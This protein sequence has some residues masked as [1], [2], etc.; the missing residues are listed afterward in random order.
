MKNP[1]VHKIIKRVICVFLLSVFIFTALSMTASVVI[2]GVM[3]QRADTLAGYAEITYARS[4]SNSARTRVY[5]DSGENRLSG[6]L[7]EAQ[8]PKGLIIIAPGMNSNSDSHLAEIIFF[9][10]KGYAVLAYDSTGVCESEGNSRV[11]LQQSKRDL[12]AAIFY[13][14]NDSELKSLPIY[15][16]GHSLGGYAVAAV[17]CEADVEAAICLSGFDSPVQT[18][19]GKAKE[20]IGV[21]ADIEYPFLYLQNRFTFGD[22]ADATA[23]ESINSVDTPILIC[24]GD[25]D[26]TIPY[27]LSVYSHEDEITNGNASFM[28]VDE[29]YRDGHV[30]MW[31]SEESA[32]YMSEVQD[33]YRDLS[34][35]Y[36]GDIPQRVLD[37]F[38]SGI[39]VK[40]AM[41]LDKDFMNKILDFMQSASK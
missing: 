7:Y 5:F 23:V 37:D 22:D 38:Y 6:Y 11:G 39:D 26:D 28:E 35:V 8:S 9:A 32:K 2:F 21:I 15:L 13:A 27:D 30:Y 41:E 1:N 36:G 20:Y 3:F 18:M 4:G 10:E 25:N 19:H 40:K 14:Q 24:R 29:K 34:D 33:E 31:L 16:Y 17:L 12:L